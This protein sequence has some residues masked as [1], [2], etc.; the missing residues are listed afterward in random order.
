MSTNELE[1]NAA[2]LK[3]LKKRIG[4]PD[5][6]RDVWQASPELG[7]QVE[8]G[9]LNGSTLE[10]PV[11]KGVLEFSSLKSINLQKN[12]KVDDEMMK[13]MQENQRHVEEINL[14]GCSYITDNGIRYLATYKNLRS[15]NLE[16]CS[17]IT[18]IGLKWIADRCPKI[19]SIN[20]NGCYHITDDGLS[21]LA[22]SCKH[23]KDIHLNGCKKISN[24]GLD[25]LSNSCSQIHTIDLLS[26]PLITDAGW[27][28]LSERCKVNMLSKYLSFFN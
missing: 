18:D 9:I 22:Q 26:C 12:N 7:Q 17:L 28:L 20:L 1:Y 10:T 16:G 6:V 23:I 13:F 3:A 4:L 27:N 25:V 8:Q 19:H 24:H 11:L 15:I 14:E 5:A 21:A 2:C